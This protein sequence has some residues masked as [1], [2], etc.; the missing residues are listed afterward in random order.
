MKGIESVKKKEV[1]K[2]HKKV[3]CS[4]NPMIGRTEGWRV[5]Q[6]VPLWVVQ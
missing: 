5:D 2:V 4:G 6:T 1:T 3:S